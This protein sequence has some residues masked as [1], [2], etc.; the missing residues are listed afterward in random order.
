[1]VAW[2][3][4]LVLGYNY[5]TTVSFKEDTKGW[6]SFKSFLPENALSMAND[7]YTFKN[8]H[9]WKHHDETVDRNTFYGD[10]TSSSV[11]VVL[12]DDP[13]SIKTFNTLN[14][15]GSQSNVPKF[16]F[17]DSTDPNYVP[18]PFQPDTDYNDQEIYNLTAK[19]GWFVEKIFTDKEEGYVNE[20]I[21][22]EGK[23]FNNINRLID[24]D[25]QTADTAD[26]TF[27]GIGF[28]DTAWSQD[29]GVD[30][31]EEVGGIGAL[32]I[33][34]VLGVG[35]VGVGGVGVG[36]DSGEEVDI[37]GGEIDLGDTGSGILPTGLGVGVDIS[38]GI[39]PIIST[40]IGPCDISTATTWGSGVTYNI[41]DVVLYQGN[42]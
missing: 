11:E 21:E 22:K 33:S 41:G 1:M 8:G 30:S 4:P 12:N 34:G 17:I 40:N 37:G 20:F 13:S 5:L 32:G 2:W 14:Y 39:D 29:L 38:V 25:L 23:W 28:A 31:G 3:M 26:F 42:Y 15:E 35:G 10:F 7:Y 19:H 24:I 16:T 27:Q 6:V 36:I 18:I 9:L